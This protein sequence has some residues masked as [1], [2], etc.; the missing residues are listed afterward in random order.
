MQSFGLRDTPIFVLR[1]EPSKG[2]F[3]QNSLITA[4]IMNPGPPGREGAV[5]LYRVLRV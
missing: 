4:H 1:I 5:P 3:S 2:T